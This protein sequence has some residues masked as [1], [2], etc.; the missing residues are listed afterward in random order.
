MAK[1]KKPK[2]H[3]GHGSIFYIASK[4]K[5]MGQLDLGKDENGK[6]IRKTVLGN[7][8]EEVEEKMQK[9]K[10]DVYSGKFV[11]ASTVT[12]KQLTMQMLNEKRAMNEIQEQTYFRHIETLKQ[13]APINDIP[14]QKVDTTMLKEL[15]LSKVDYSQSYIRKIHMMLNQG[16]AEAVRRKIIVENP[17]TDVRR[18]KSSKKP[19]KIRAMTMGEQKAFLEVL[20][21][22]R[23]LYADQML[24]SM[25]TGMRMGEI[26]ALSVK[27]I[28]LNFNFINI[29]KTIAKGERNE[30]FLNTSPK[31]EKGNRQ[32][33]INS[34]VKHVIDKVL[35]DY[36]P[37]KDGMLFHTTKGTL[38]PT[39][40]V[41]AEFRRIV[42][43]YGIKDTAVPGDLTLH[44]LRHTY[45]TRCIESGMPPKVL[46]NLLGHTDIK[47]TLD[48][49]SDVFDNFQ[50]ENVA[51][52]DEYLSSA[53]LVVNA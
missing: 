27:D 32:V 35:K 53:G 2:N 1:A 17:M 4:K 15:V 18:P 41:N 30:A 45:A 26:D 6:R 50:N 40:S 34:M 31:T 48:T 38:V 44:S 19:R 9:V 10:F 22:E 13:C 28:N 39:T 23:V 37:T 25:F 5:R 3:Y 7:S 20:K 21:T 33:P 36:V 43:T 49:Y 11:D 24:I 52:V 51:K 47:V 14:I 29:D 8:P 46:Q 16:F 42:E 12:F